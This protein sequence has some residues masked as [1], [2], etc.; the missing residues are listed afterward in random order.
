MV[1][2]VNNVREG[3]RTYATLLKACQGFLKLSPDLAG[4]IRRDAH[5][6]DAIRSQTSILSSYP[7]ADAA[8]DA[9]KKEKKL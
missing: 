4:I 7:N 6:R 2:A 9:L 1:N 8:S 3:E 5:V